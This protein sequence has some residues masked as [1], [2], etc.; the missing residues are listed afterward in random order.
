MFYVQERIKYEINAMVIYILH[1]LGS[2]I[3]QLSRSI[4]L[5]PRHKEIISAIKSSLH[6]SATSLFLLYVW[7]AVLTRERRMTPVSSMMS[8]QGA[9]IFS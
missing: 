3:L 1:V 8:T 9:V 5:L 6:S 7:K 4:S 2:T